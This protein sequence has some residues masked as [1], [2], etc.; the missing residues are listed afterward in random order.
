MPITLGPPPTRAAVGDFAWQ[1][2][3]NDLYKMLSSTGVVSWVNVSKAGSSLGDLQDKAHS[4]LTSILGTGSYHLSATEAGRV[5]ATM[6]I[7]S[8]AVNPTTTD[9]PSNTWA[10][11]KNTSSG[12]LKL[13]AND[14]GTLKSVTL[15]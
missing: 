2:W 10:L 4:Y 1:A 5:S 3:Q 7:T 9:I 11:Y 6:T 12:A 14:G 13:W 8:S 15:T